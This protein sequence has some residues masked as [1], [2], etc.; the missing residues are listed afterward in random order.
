MNKSDRGY[1]CFHRTIINPLIL[2]LTCVI[3]LTRTSEALMIVEDFDFY[4]E[5]P[6]GNNAGG[7]GF[8]GAW[9]FLDKPED[10]HIDNNSNLMYNATGYSVSS[11]GKGKLV[12]FYDI[13]TDS[14]LS[15]RRFAEPFTGESEGRIVW[16]SMLVYFSSNSGR[17]G[18]YLNSATGHRSQSD[19]GFLCV[20]TDFRKLVNGTLTSSGLTLS[21]DTTHLILGRVDLKD[22]NSS[23]VKFWLDP[24]DCTSADTL[25]NAQLTY[26]AVF[27]GSI[28]NI[29][30]DVYA[31]AS[32]AASL[33]ALRVSDGNGDAL[34]A[35]QDVTKETPATLFGP[36]QFKSLSDL[37]NHFTLLNSETNDWVSSNDENYGD[38]GFLRPIQNDEFVHH[39]YGIDTDGKIAGGNDL[40]GDCTIDYD[41]RTHN[42][43][44]RLV[45]VFLLG[46]N[47][48]N[49]S[50]K[51]WVLNDDR[52]TE[53]QQ[54]IIKAYYSRTMGGIGGGGIYEAVTNDLDCSDWVHVRLDVRRINNF[55]QVEV[56]NRIWNSASDFRAPPTVDSTITYDKNTSRV[57]DGEIG[58]SIYASPDA[59]ADIDNIAIYRYGGAPERYVP[60]GTLI[61]IN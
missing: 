48:T 51:L 18:L 42:S 43:L 10:G 14:I 5:G 47:T 27:G 26:D 22:T 29:G 38:G 46:N 12:A 36:I 40:F 6:L 55:T 2:F 34:Q 37:T 61:I 50:D 3:M 39:V 44:D 21:A 4:P 28:T 11:L 13:S 25:G 15:N 8:C 56:R 54:N 45:G 53:S 41:M 59:T 17:V 33:D 23:T 30:L 19:A 24:S 58:F 9:S 32:T 60:K 16:L 35:F 7:S 49:R 52:D 20:G 57:T 31:P 1:L